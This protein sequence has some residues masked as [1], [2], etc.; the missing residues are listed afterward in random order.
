MIGK[1]IRQERLNRKISST[2]LAKAVNIN[3]GFLTHIEKGERNPSRTVLSKICKEL[4]L[5]YDFMLSLL[6]N[7]L[8]DENIEYDVTQYTPTSKVLYAESIS[9]IECPKLSESVS[10]ITRMPDDSMTP[11]ISK[12]ALLHIKYTSFIQNGDIC[13]AVLNG[14]TIV[15][16]FFATDAG[17]KLHAKNNNNKDVIITADDTLDIIGKIIAY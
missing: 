12:G 14:K 13:I 17:I 3:V 7:S 9:L 1:V 11:L 8:S 10:F 2:D 4:D 16:E 15:R 5:S 6:Q